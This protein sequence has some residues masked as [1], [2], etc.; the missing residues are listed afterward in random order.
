VSEY[1]EISVLDPGVVP[2]VESVTRSVYEKTLYSSSVFT[3]SCRVP[4]AP[5]AHV[6]MSK[7]PT[8]IYYDPAGNVKAVGAET[9]QRGL[10][11]VEGIE[12]WVKAEWYGFRLQVSRI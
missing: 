11:Q 3:F 10:Y 12:N 4:A 8:I 1:C 9:L 2:Q 7:I 6:S 5:L